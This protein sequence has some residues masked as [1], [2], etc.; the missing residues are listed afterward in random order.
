MMFN[1]LMA[2]ARGSS[3]VS[4]DYAVLWADVLLYDLLM[5]RKNKRNYLCP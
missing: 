1:F 3:P 4:V 5:L 2:K